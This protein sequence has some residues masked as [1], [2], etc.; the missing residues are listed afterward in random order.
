MKPG[1]A[2]ENSIDRSALFAAI[3]AYT[4]WGF[5]P[6]FLKQLSVVPALE[7]IAHRVIWAVPVLLVIMAFRKQFGE[8]RRVISSYQSLRW[9]LVSAVLIS[10][11]WLVFVWAVNSGHILAVSLGY[12]LNP[13]LNVLVGTLFLGERL[14]RT[15]WGAVAIACFAVAVLAGGAFNTLWISLSLA[16]SF[17]AYGVVRKYAPVGAIPGLAIET[18]LLLPAAIGAIIWFADHGPAQYWTGDIRISLLLV[19]SGAITAIP[20]LLFATAARRMSYS[21]LGFI[22]YIGPTVQFLLGIFLYKEPLS[23]VR[24]VAFALIWCALAIFSWDAV[25][26]MRSAD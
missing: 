4:I 11:N 9:M 22:Q 25:R 21:A 23:G 26:R 5:L 8:F 14:N 15:Q 13:L 7:I 17:C 2:P 12:Y 20:L 3:G 1:S 19:A 16:G 18:I 24:L 10:A 6:L